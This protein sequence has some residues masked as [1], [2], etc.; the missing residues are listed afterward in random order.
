MCPLPKA[1]VEN[2][3]AKVMAL[4]GGAFGRWLGHEGRAL[5]KEAQRANSSFHH[6]RTQQEVCDPE[7]DFHQNPAMLV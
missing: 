2:L 4:R 6:A 7:E 3:M 5:L 1:Y